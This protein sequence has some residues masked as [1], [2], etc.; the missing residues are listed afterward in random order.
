MNT[1]FIVESNFG[2]LIHWAIQVVG[3]V[4]VMDHSCISP[5]WFSS[6]T[7]QV[8]SNHHRTTNIAIK[9]KILLWSPKTYSKLLCWR[10]L[11]KALDSLYRKQHFIISSWYKFVS[12][13]IRSRRRRCGSNREWRDDDLQ[14]VQLKVKL[15][16]NGDPFLFKLGPDSHSLVIATNPDKVHCLCVGALS[17]E[18]SNYYYPTWFLT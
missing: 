10:L 9:I 5:D 1:N 13:R 12:Q 16:W 11:Q 18:I 15:C 2:L 17:T 8:L 3:Q 4:C 7:T 6:T 14:W